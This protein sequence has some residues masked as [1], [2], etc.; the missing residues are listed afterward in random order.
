MSITEKEYI[1]L[2][3]IEQNPFLSQQELAEKMSLSRS[4]I[5]TMITNLIQKGRIQ[6]RAYVVSKGGSVVCVGGMNIDRKYHI[7]GQFIPQTS[8]PVTSSMSVGGVVRNIAENLGR[9]GEQ[10]QLLS[11]AG[12]DQDYEWIKSKSQHFIN[13]QNVTQLKSHNTSSYSA[14]L[15]ETGNMQ[16]ALADMS[17]CD[18]MNLDWIQSKR[19]MLLQA[20]MII[21]DLNLPKETIHYLCH[22]ATDNQIPLCV[23]PV[24][25][26]KM[27]HLPQTLNGITWLIVNLDESRAYFGVRDDVDIE[28]LANMWLQRG[29]QHVIITR[30]TQSSYY[31]STTSNGVYVTPPAVENVIDVTGAGDSFSAGLIKGLLLKEPVDVCI[32]LAQTNAYY[33]VQSPY[34]VRLNLSEPQLMSEMKKLVKEGKL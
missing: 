26:P 10:V 13:M 30:G 19:S 17:I 28:T 11:V 3:F 15:D 12:E 5:A 20:N 4:T 32:K 23:V 25:A 14:V 7:L 16:F 8:N 34:T 27:V 31:L 2:N 1:L 6:G 18:E 22:L 21:I 33:T 9:L 24:S 29:V